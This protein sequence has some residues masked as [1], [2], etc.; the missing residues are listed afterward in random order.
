MKPDHPH[1]TNKCDKM[2]KGQMNNLMMNFKNA[3]RDVEDGEPEANY[4]E[5]DVSRPIFITG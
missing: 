5:Y 3:C 2:E 1:F 4:N